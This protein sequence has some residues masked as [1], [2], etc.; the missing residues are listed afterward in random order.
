MTDTAVRAEQQRRLLAALAADEAEDARLFARRMRHRAELAR[1]W[2]DTPQGPEEFGVIELAG[3]ARIGQARASSQLVDGVRLVQTFPRTLALLEAGQ[4]YRETAVLLLQLTAACAEA[5]QAAVET[6][7]LEQITRANTADVRRIVSAAVL[8]VEAELDPDLTRQ[9]LATARRG[10]RVWTRPGADGMGQA[11][12][13]LDLVALKRWALDLTEL[14]RAQKV[15]DR[16]TGTV[17]SHSQRTADVFA[18]LP[19]RHLALLQALRQGRLGQLLA[20]AQQRVGHSEQ[21]SDASDTPAPIDQ[22][23]GSEGPVSPEQDLVL[24]LSVPLRNPLVVNVHIPMTTV[25]E[26][27]QRCGHLEGLGP[28][29]AEHARLLIPYA[30]LRRVFVDPHSGVPF[31]V[32]PQLHPPLLAPDE[33]PDPDPDDG[34]AQR[35]RQRLLALLTPTATVDRAEP[36]HD[37]STTLRG[38]LQL[39]DQR[40]SGIGCSQPAS[41]CHL[42]HQQRYPDGPTSAWNLDHK[43]SRCHR[44]KHHGWT[45]THDPRTGRHTWTSPLGHTYTRPGVWQ[46]PPPV[47]HELVLTAPRPAHPEHEPERLPDQDAPLWSD[48]RRPAADPHHGWNDVPAF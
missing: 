35:V 45:T 13:E 5:V 7:V 22:G 11:G 48:P 31:G 6:R 20:Q 14:V 10:R 39:R 29:S 28:L 3:T 23:P 41:R 8:E 33:P 16:C 15:V 42:D 24:L 26:R 25:L 1:L 17:R 34:T 2:P 46:A 44:A 30:G 21:P 37:P 38:Y 36:G 19:S 47:P 32:D 18:E 40:C 12:A 4:M 27:D 43:S 9:R